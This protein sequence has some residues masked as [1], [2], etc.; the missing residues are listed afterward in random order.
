[1]KNVS[2]PNFWNQRYKDNNTR[3]DIG[4]PTPIVTDY[5]KK[6]K[7]IG[8]VC[9]LGCGTGYDAIEFALNGNDVYAVDFSIEALNRLRTIKPNNLKLKLVHQDIFDLASKYKNYF[10]LV[11]SIHAFVL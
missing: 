9:I 3:W 1:M 7:H 5:L 4:Q 10:D 2:N 8:K 11:L 6:N